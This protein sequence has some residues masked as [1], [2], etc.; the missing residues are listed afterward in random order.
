MH[1]QEGTAIMVSTCKKCGGT[2]EES[3][4]ICDYC[5]KAQEDPSTNQV[6]GK[7]AAIMPCKKCGGNKAESD[8]ICDYCHKAQEES[9][10]NRAGMLKLRNRVRP[11]PR[12]RK[13]YKQ[14]IMKKV[15]D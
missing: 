1:T 4:A 6:V 11:Y 12:P 7:K 9:N 3:D 15:L 8:A 10:V 2:K 5:C 13:K 14:L